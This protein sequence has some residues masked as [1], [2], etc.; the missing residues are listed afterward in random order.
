MWR[1]GRGR[2]GVVKDGYHIS[3][4]TCLLK[5]VFHCRKEYQVIK[6]FNCFSQWQA[7]KY[8]YRKI[9]LHTL[10][11][12]QHFALGS[13]TRKRAKN[14]QVFISKIHQ[15]LRVE[16]KNF[17]SDLGFF[18][19]VMAVYDFISFNINPVKK[20]C[21]VFIEAF[22]NGFNGDSLQLLLHQTDFHFN[23]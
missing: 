15:V 1:Q 9:L 2:V 11:A 10:V 5:R 14:L 19:F 4:F 22:S 23:I 13:I 18:F 21:F 17:K 12:L 8:F 6:D 16:K 3:V 7:V 20:F